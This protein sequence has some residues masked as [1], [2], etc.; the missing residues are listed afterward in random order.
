MRNDRESW[1]EGP[2]QD[3]PDRVD[4]VDATTGLLCT[5]IRNDFGAWCGYVGVSRQHPYYLLHY[6]D[7]TGIYAHGGLTYAGRLMHAE[8]AAERYGL[9][10]IWWLGFDCAHSG[11]YM[12]GTERGK[13]ET[14]KDIRFV[15]SRITDLAL[16]LG[17]VAR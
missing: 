10:A 5:A 12:P 15:I 7:I 2:W 16:Q 17:A 6:D 11:D 8:E 4:W 9:S 14:Y 3:E 1:G 13:H